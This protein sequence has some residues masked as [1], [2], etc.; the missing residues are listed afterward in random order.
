MSI[1]ENDEV[2]VL[3]RLEF[4]AD[5]SKEELRVIQ[6]EV[7]DLSD[8]FS[9]L[10]RYSSEWKDVLTPISNF[11]GEVAH[12]LEKSLD[13]QKDLAQY[14]NI[15]NEGVQKYNEQLEKRR[16]LEY[17]II[18][19][20]ERALPEVNY[21]SAPPPSKPP[22]A[23]D[24]LPPPPEEPEEEPEE[25]SSPRPSEKSGFSLGDLGKLKNAGQAALRGR[26]TD[27]LAS[28]LSKSGGFLG[29]LGSGLAAAGPWIAGAT[30]VIG[31]AY[32]GINTYADYQKE[33]QKRGLSGADA[34]LFKVQQDAEI[35]ALALD[36]WISTEQARQ[37]VMAGL[38]T[39]AK[40]DNYDKI[41]DFLTEN[42]R[43]MN[44]S[45]SKSMQLMK[46]SVTEGS[47]S[48]ENLSAT[49]KNIKADV[50]ER[51]GDQE[52]ALN[53]AQEAAVTA[54]KIGLSADASSALMESAGNMLGDAEVSE[55][56]RTKFSNTLLSIGGD[57]LYS[58]PI[59]SQIA[60]RRGI[61]ISEVA[62]LPSGEFVPEYY[63]VLGEYLKS[64]EGSNPHETYEIAKS[65]IPAFKNMSFQEFQ[66]FYEIFTD[67]EKTKQAI[68]LDE[69][70]SRNKAQ[71][72]DAKDMDREKSGGALNG[73]GLKIH[74]NGDA[75]YNPFGTD[76]DLNAK[77]GME[78]D[79]TGA[80]LGAAYDS[81]NL[82]QVVWKDSQG[83]EHT[84]QEYYDTLKEEQRIAGPGTDYALSSAAIYHR[85]HAWLDD[86]DTADE[87]NKMTWGIKTATGEVNYNTGLG[88]AQIVN[89]AKNNVS[90]QDLVSGSAGKVSTEITLSSEAKRWFSI[91]DPEGG[92]PDDKRT[93]EG[94]S[95]SNDPKSKRG[96]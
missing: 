13:N 33:G 58:S 32:E 37:L 43:D 66:Q 5:D 91:N 74:S 39:G 7:Q 73:G 50:G 16:D 71:A 56:T 65:T 61:D 21:S 76:H 68:G 89:S 40:G 12:K 51:E 84:L 90:P 10:S 87:A 83:N 72:V 49:M 25:K 31:A 42:L 94:N 22:V 9:I 95:P 24:T 15:L 54:G 86:L 41:T 92:T 47:M 1:F 62:E 53:R 19:Q 6:T 11:Y 88:L 34:A 38:N 3:A 60:A 28:V 29:E 63:S 52:A 23:T 46:A 26:G 75:W 27:A 14:Q 35:K 18:N 64:M 78:G 2:S 17:E 93:R 55:E 45:V 36:P 85:E 80:I 79:E 81:G 77:W 70:T 96:D 4:G 57:N 8:K 59:Y 67:P 44:V 20:R 48:I 30:A 82:S 69:I